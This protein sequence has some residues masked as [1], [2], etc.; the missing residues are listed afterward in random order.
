MEIKKIQLPEIS[1]SCY[2]L[3]LKALRYYLFSTTEF[4][5]DADLTIGLCEMIDYFE[6][7]Y[8]EVNSKIQLPTIYDY[9]YQLLLNSLRYYITAIPEFTVD[10]NLVV[11]LYKLIDYIEMEQQEVKILMK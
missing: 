2:Q 10:T 6:Q 9:S 7:T 5:I 8:K 11:K 1:F 4:I 3:I